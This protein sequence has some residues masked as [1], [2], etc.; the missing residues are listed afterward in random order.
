[1]KLGWLLPVL[2]GL[3][4]AGPVFA[5]APPVC[6][7]ADMA[8]VPR[9]ARIRWRTQDTLPITA[10]LPVEDDAQLA[11]VLA[12][13][14][15][16]PKES[17]D[18]P[19]APPI[20]KYPYGSLE[21]YGFNLTFVVSETGRVTCAL[22]APTFPATP[23]SMNYKREG[24]LAETGEWRFKPYL[25]DGKP[26]R[27]VVKLRINEEE[28]PKSHVPMPS[29]NPADVTITQDMR[30]G[31]SRNYHVEIH[32]DGTA[33]YTS[34][35]IWDVLGPQSYRV[36][37]KKVQALVGQVADSDFWSLRDQ[38]GDW[39]GTY[40]EDFDR[41]NVTVGGKTKSLTNYNDW[42]TGMPE[43]A[44]DLSYAVMEAANTGFWTRPTLATVAQL[45][46]NG[47]D[48]GSRRSGQLLVQW[49][50]NVQIKDEVIQALMDEGAPRTQ[51]VYDTRV[52]EYHGLVDGAL[53]AGRVQIA[54]TLIKKGALLSNGK[55]DIAKV[56]KA[57]GQAIDSGKLAAVDLVVPFH[58]DMTFPD[59]D[60]PSLKVSV[61]RRLGTVSSNCSADALPVA[62][63]LIDLGGDVDAA[64]S[65]GTTLL[66]ACSQDIDAVRFLL[67]H[68]A[69]IDA[70]DEDGNTPMATTYD[71]DVALL[72]LS[73]GA[74]PRQ[75]AAA[76][77]L[78]FNV[79][80]NDWSKVKVWLESHGFADVLKPVPGEGNEKLV[81]VP[82]T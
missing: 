23:F 66:H 27:V 59:P 9:P 55:V 1:M 25:I 2:A 32:G 60:D 30:Y 76:E 67:D 11:A 28:L 4:V 15:A 24:L 3:L 22:M 37:P 47:F 51:L 81:E 46:S 65:D 44:Q 71:E 31:K 72:L 73:R 61:L 75:E 39:S 41:T 53:W 78:R 63:R 52:R 34:T 42:D 69:N 77:N 6:T 26:S 13:I 58:P 17:L 70:V 12:T 7:E 82:H 16:S 18:L 21:S 38:Y 35:D 43:A 45:K 74:D 33:I 29:G 54:D 10:K 62:Q 80:K 49:V 68:G 14:N 36:D 8:D 64:L 48:L 56:N 57:F 20:L 50:R 40:A 19:F 5:A 79:L